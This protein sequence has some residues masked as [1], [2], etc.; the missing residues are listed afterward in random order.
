MKNTPFDQ[1]RQLILKSSTPEDAQEKIS[2][3]KH[4]PQEELHKSLE[5]YFNTAE[6]LASQGQTKEIS[7]MLRVLE[8]FNNK[9]HDR[10]LLHYLAQAASNNALAELKSEAHPHHQ[11]MIKAM[12]LISQAFQD[13]DKIDDTLKK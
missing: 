8:H 6:A 1:A 5:E 13:A 4:L 7:I 12:S 2:A 10:M 9:S 3:L 11:D